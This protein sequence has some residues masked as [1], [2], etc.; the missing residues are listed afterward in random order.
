MMRRKAKDHK[1]VREASNLFANLVRRQKLGIPCHETT[2]GD[3]MRCR[4]ESVRRFYFTR[5]VYDPPDQKVLGYIGYSDAFCCIC[6][7]VVVSKVNPQVARELQRR[8]L[9]R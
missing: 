3:C 5:R 2:R 4:R 8:M 7:F 6:S 1:Q 9:S